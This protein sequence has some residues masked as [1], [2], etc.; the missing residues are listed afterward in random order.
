MSG[1]DRARRAERVVDWAQNVGAD[2]LVAVAT[3]ELRVLADLA[4]ARRDLDAQLRDAVLRARRRGRSWSEIGAMLGVSKQA[5]Q[6][7]YGPRP[8]AA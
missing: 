8:S 5:V 3:D 7:K 6:R 4:D 1:A 2:D